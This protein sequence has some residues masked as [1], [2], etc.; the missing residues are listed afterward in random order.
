MSTGAIARKTGIFLIRILLAALIGLNF[1]PFIG[2]STA[3]ANHVN[4]GLTNP[5]FEDD[6]TGW[7]VVRP[8]ADSV[9]VI[10]SDNFY[11]GPGNHD[12]PVLVT[13]YRGDKM[14]RLGTPKKVNQKQQKGKNSVEQTFVATEESIT[15]AFR[16]CTWENRGDDSF[17]ID[18][19]DPDTGESVGGLTADFSENYDGDTSFPVTIS[20]GS[21][22]GYHSHY[23]PGDFYDSGWVEMTVS[24]LQ[25]SDTYKLVYSVIGGKYKTS[26]TWA[27][28]DSVNLPPLDV[29]PDFTNPGF[30]DDLTGW[31]IVEP[32]ADSVTVTGSDSFYVSNSKHGSPVSVDPYQGEKMLRLGTPKKE[33]QKQ[34]K[35][36]N[37]VEQTFAATEES[38]TI[39]FRLC[40][41]ENRGDDSFLIDI[42]DPYTGESVPGLTAVF[43]ENYDGD[44]TFPVNI[45]PG[46]GHGY[47]FW[48]SPRNEFYDS[49]WVEVSISGLQVSTAYKL[50]Y[51]VIGGRNSSHAT[52]AYL[53]N[54]SSNAAPVAE[55][56][57]SPSDP[58]EGDFIEFMDSS[59]VP[60]DP[61]GEIV[62]WEWQITWLR[63]DLEENPVSGSDLRNPFFIPVDEGNYEVKLTVTDSDGE[64]G[65]V[66][67]LITVDNAPPAVN[68]LNIEVPAGE[69][70][71]LFGRFIDPGWQ[72]LNHSAVWTINGITV[73]ALVEETDQAFMG[74]GI[75][76]GTYDT[77]NSLPGTVFDGILTVFDDSGDS[78]S[79]AFTI[80]VMDIDA[81]S[82]EPNDTTE[83]APEL[84]SDAIHLS[85]IQSAGDVDVFEIVAADG[86]PLPLG[87]EALVTLENLPNDYD[88]LIL[89]E[90]PSGLEPGGFQ[91]GGFQ[92]GGFQMGGFQMGAYQMGGYQ[93]GG[94]QMGG[95][96]MGGYQMGGFQMGAFQ[97]GGFQMGGYQMGGFQMGAYQ[98]GGFQMGA[99]QMGGYQMGAFQ[100]GAYQ[101]GGFQM[102]GFQMGGFQMGGGSADYPLSQII[103]SGIEGTPNDSISGTDISLAELGISLEE[104]TGSSSENYQIVGFSAS[105][106]LQ[107]ETLLANVDTTGTRLFVVIIG[108]NDAVSLQPYSLRIE[109]S[110]PLDVAGILAAQG[111]VYPAPE[112]LDYT[113]TETV[114]IPTDYEGTAPK[115]L[116]VTQRERI[117]GRYG[118]ES[119][120]ALEDTYA[121]LSADEKIAGKIV[122]VPESIYEDWDNDYSSIDAVNEV[123]F[124]IRSIINDQMAAYP[125]IEYVVIL[126]NDDI[127]P[128]H[129]D[130][131]ITSI[132]NER[133]Y[134]MTSFLRPGSPLFFSVLGG[135]VLTD[136]YL[137]DE[138]PLVWQ[139]RPSYVPD[140]A[141]ARMVERPEEMIAAADAF[142]LSGGELAFSTAL[143]TGYDFFD[144]GAQAVI[145][146]ITDNAGIVPDSLLGGS[147]AWDADDLL[148]LFLGE[149][150]YDLN[151]INAH[152]THYSALS[153]EGFDTSDYTDIMTSLEVDDAQL[154]DTVVYTMGCHA[155]L[156]VP[157]ESAAD[158]EALG[159]DINP[160]MD[161]AQA[162]NRAVFLGSTGYGYGDDEGIGGT[163]YLMNLFTDQ[164]LTPMTVGNALVS[165]KQNYRV[166]T[167]TWTAYDDKSSSEFTLYGLPQ[168]SVSLPN[169]TMTMLSFYQQS[170][171]GNND[172]IILTDTIDPIPHET[173]S[174]SYYTSDG[175][176]QSTAFRPV[177]PRIIVPLGSDTENPAHGT[178]FLNGTYHDVE[179]FNPVITRPTNEWEVVSEEIQLLPP[180]FWPSEIAT[181]KTLETGTGLIQNLVVIPGR[182]K[183]TGLEEINGKIQI[184]G[185][186]RLFDNL[187]LEV[188]RSS[189][190]DFTPPVIN[191]IDIG[192][193]TEGIYVTVNA[194]DPSGISRI[195]VNH[196][197]SELHEISIAGEFVA[198]EPSNE[199]EYTIYLSDIGDDP[200]IVQVVD[201][202]GNIALATG[203]GVKLSFIEVTSVPAVMTQENSEVTLN[204]TIS[205][206]TGLTQP[207]FYTWRMGDGTFVQGVSQDGNIE[208]GHV[209]KDDSRTTD[210]VDFFIARLKVTD[211]AGGVGVAFTLVR[212]EDL[213]PVVSIDS[214]VEQNNDEGDTVTLEGSFT[215]EGTL[216]TH[217]GEIAWGDGTT[218][219]LAIVQGSGFGT[220]TATHL[221][222]DNP[223]NEE[224]TYLISLT[225]TDKDTL[226]GENSTVVTVSNVAPVLD[227]APS[228]SPVYE[229][230]TAALGGNFT[231]PG[232][233]DTHTVVVDWGDGTTEGP[234]A[235]PGQGSGT[236]SIPHV[237]ADDKPGTDPDTYT[238]SANLSDKD[239]GFNI[240]AT[241]ITVLNLPPAVTINPV[242]D[243]VYEGTS[244]TLTGGFTDAGILDTHTAVIDWGDN[245]I[246]PLPVVQGSGIGTFSAT[247]VYGSSGD[248]AV[249]VNVTDDDFGSGFDTIGVTVE[250][251]T[252]PA[253]VCFEVSLAYN[254]APA[255]FPEVTVSGETILDGVYP[256]WCIDTDTHI[257]RLTLYCDAAVYSSLP[258]GMVEYP[259]N[260]DLVLWILNQDYVGKDST[261]NGTYTYGDVQRAI[262]ALI[263]DVNSVTPILRAWDQ[264]R[265]NEILAAADA[266][267]EG[268]EPGYGEYMWIILAADNTQPVIIPVRTGN[269][270]EAVK[271]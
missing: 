2:S 174:G 165:A 193:D 258:E 107:A 60:D 161:I 270:E 143:V 148:S 104:I 242:E 47:Y 59:Y 150:P 156:N 199:H 46:S 25:S 231:D 98:M 53:D 102:G 260:F 217:T 121:G 66:T 26:A 219:P 33:N 4:T 78:S 65:D 257:E 108:A 209:Y 212:V 57:I 72:D 236:F 23:Q 123:V 6:L 195:L 214:V 224:N 264:C 139:G 15:I 29:N 198:D 140:I 226:T 221:Y 249:T 154:Y 1:I 196:F 127:V 246:E 152:Y 67:Q 97:M 206:F 240:A 192:R 184:I 76:T 146:S 93:M 5:G 160:Q 238:I 205:N 268:Y 144:D 182:F 153:A 35:G 235:V 247:H 38:I 203:K 256:G 90:R 172:T 49:D 187:E 233:L 137:V 259:E 124:N 216:D 159:L 155:G 171:E 210:P 207:V 263:D 138:H 86:S 87:A 112:G 142:T 116:F 36:N 220:F 243:P 3:Y 103:F 105:Q 269:G 68:A 8:V 114:T 10:D 271:G 248:Y 101:M 117:I 48:W 176:S 173:G 191:G 151:N 129:R 133:Q 58:W 265:V 190:N 40:S 16:L 34:P 71:R 222:P 113:S 91:M 18:I 245:I 88:M 22:N 96:Q 54:V 158:A 167:S 81:Y 43:S 194:S 163:E 14:L 131:D 253:Q 261:C 230:D 175:D 63:P 211:S 50:V 32:V 100:M 250:T 74:T 84:T 31:N 252:L 179:G 164:L 12:S 215:D 51:A 200:I 170:L 197:D 28:F 42:Q 157:D 168:Y 188:T 166:S 21:E 106:G 56:Q 94:Y 83:T 20:P 118:Q 45:S 111:I 213:P 92:M 7:N 55:F 202:A 244:F 239:G 110:R 262:W 141:V 82:Y 61:D 75:V 64:T 122:S 180:T 189:S 136:D 17:I 134:A 241:E 225:V 24:G 145:D 89:S 237:Y 37:S 181:I 185:T 208:I 79:N 178:L 85:C 39:S 128:F 19:Q 227:I 120:D 255:Y 218:E 13:P 204:A 162:L 115:T 41:W 149:H 234:V 169:L 95:F 30:E 62:S 251:S 267:G 177:Q 135:Y 228:L 201:G 11:T 126:G 266:G 80:T 99:F 147:V 130:P 229:G 70:A 52:W 73:P 77:G 44:T 132:G 232:T 183:S 254:G 186:E 109:T 9:S 69:E 125:S 27:Y 223:D 119:W